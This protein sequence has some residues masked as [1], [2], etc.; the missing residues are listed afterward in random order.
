MDLGGGLMLSDDLSRSGE[1]NLSEPRK[2]SYKSSID[3]WC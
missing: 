2:R 3:T 1:V